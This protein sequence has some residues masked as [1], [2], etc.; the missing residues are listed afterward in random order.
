M[1]AW[2]G[3]GLSRDLPRPAGRSF[4]EKMLERQ[5]DEGGRMKS[6][7]VESER[8]VKKSLAIKDERI[9]HQEERILSELMTPT[10][11]VDRF[12]QELTALGGRL[13]RTR[14]QGL[15]QAVAG[16]IKDLG[17]EEICAWQAGEL[18]DGLLAGLEQVGIKIYFTPD[19]ALRLGLTGALAAAAESGTLYLPGSGSR[20]PSVSLLPEI[21]LAVL[22]AN[23]IMESLG[24]L[25][26]M[27]E[28]RQALRQASSS[29]LISG[30]SRTGDIELT[31]T[32][33]VHGPCQVIVVCV[34]D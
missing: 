22:E 23:H 19:P 1:P 8:S 13:V 32:I 26:K 16:L 20:P 6:R 25:F 14:R 12:E 9:V 18:P 30:P 31:L 4:H 3:W 27:P 11:L 17:I 10:A 5:R 2:T 7:Q 33:G 34:Q 24:E 29:T 28:I 15:V 21:H